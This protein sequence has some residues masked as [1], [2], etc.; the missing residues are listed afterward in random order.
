MRQDNAETLQAKLMSIDESV[1]RNRPR[2]R[3]DEQLRL[4]QHD[5][6]SLC[7]TL[8][9]RRQ[10]C[11]QVPKIKRSKRVQH[12]LSR[13][14]LPRSVRLLQPPVPQSSPLRALPSTKGADIPERCANSLTLSLKLLKLNLPR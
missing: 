1:S 12:H 7:W 14:I 9:P 5:C 4:G 11:R 8:L 13:V 10:V 2:G 3:A 6:D